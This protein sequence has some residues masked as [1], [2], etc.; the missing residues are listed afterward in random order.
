MIDAWST[1]VPVERISVMT[2]PPAGASSRTL[3]ERF[4]IATDLRVELWDDGE[5][6]PRNVSLGAAQLEVI[7]KLNGPSSPG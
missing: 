2:V 5:P 7:R 6:I 3:L 4:T 1:A